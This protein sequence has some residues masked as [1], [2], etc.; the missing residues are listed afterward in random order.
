MEI[1]SESLRFILGIKIKQFR[2]SA[3]Y[4]LKQLSEKTGLSVSY[5]S[6]IEKGKKYPKPEKI[7]L[8][9][10]ALDRTFDELVSLQLDDELNPLSRIAKFTSIKR[11]PITAIRYWIG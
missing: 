3:G 10:H 9:A 1:N 7:V 11:L 4:S 2:Q 5:L 8:L 6:E